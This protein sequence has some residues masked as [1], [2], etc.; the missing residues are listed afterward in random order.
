MSEKWINPTDQLPNNAQKVIVDIEYLGELPA[1]FHTT[2]QLLG[3]DRIFENVFILGRNDAI[4]RNDR[5][6]GWQPSE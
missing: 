5:I 2:Y 6:K 4:V 3:Y 1:I